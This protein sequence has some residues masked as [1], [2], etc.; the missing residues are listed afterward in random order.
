[1]TGP[2]WPDPDRTD[3]FAELADLLAR[4]AVAVT[5]EGDWLRLPRGCRA[6]AFAFEVAPG[7]LQLDVVFEPWLGTHVVESCAGFGPTRAQQW[8]DAWRSFAAGSFHVLLAALLYDE[9]APVERT[10]WEI[11]GRVRAITLGDITCRGQPPAVERWRAAVRAMIEGSGLPDGTHWIRA[12]ASLE[13]DRQLDNEVLLDNEPWEYGQE[14]LAGFTWPP[15]AGVASA[16]LFLIVQGGAD[17]S[18]AIAMLIELA[19]REDE[20]IV[21]ALEASGVAP[22][23]AAALVA[24]VPLAFGRILLT[25]LG[26][27]LA[28]EGVR[29]SRATGVDTRF[30]IADDPVFA[31]AS[32]LAERGTLTQAQFLAVARRSPEVKLFEQLADAGTEPAKCLIGAPHLSV[33]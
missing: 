22:A 13:G 15:I 10:A 23:D 25:P 20:A 7:A 14:A 17:A 21:A 5:R 32:W 26:V 4:H 31:E 27:P 11:D 16:R 1:M 9:R 33:P 3:A 24:L 19:D 12:Y 30:A 6:R 8:T 29:V 2:T 28:D 18:R